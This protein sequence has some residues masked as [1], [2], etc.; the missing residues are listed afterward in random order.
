M[1]TWS[2]L[3][4]EPGWPC[5]VECDLPNKCSTLPLWG[6][7]LHRSGDFD[8]CCLRSLSFRVRSPG[9]LDRKRGQV[10]LGS[11]WG[12]KEVTPPR[13]G[14]K[15]PDTWKWHSWITPHNTGINLMQSHQWL[16]PNPH[17]EENHPVNE[18][19][20]I[21]AVSNYCISGRL[22]T[23]QKGTHELIHLYLLQINY[24]E[25]RKHRTVTGLKGKG[26]LERTLPFISLP[27]LEAL[28]SLAL[29]SGLF[30]LGFTTKL[31]S[32]PYCSDRHVLLLSMDQSG[33][34][35]A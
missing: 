8:I 10:K 9:C 32:V 18:I 15:A 16:Q 6:L 2:S 19:Q 24:R 26:R 12:E 7:A 3:S 27:Y 20:S 22:L 4:A 23:H 35:G 11:K 17:G 31:T 28:W 25:T 1:K 13:A 34:K 5:P 14:T 30:S 33:W 29:N 21:T